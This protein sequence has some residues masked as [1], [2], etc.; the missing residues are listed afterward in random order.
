MYSIW[1]VFG[2]VKGALGFKAAEQDHTGNTGAAR[3]KYENGE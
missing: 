2:V 1:T 3:G